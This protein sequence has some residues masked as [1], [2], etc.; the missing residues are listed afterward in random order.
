MASRVKPNSESTPN[1]ELGVQVYFLI[2]R[3]SSDYR[4]SYYE[5]SAQ[6][7]SQNIMES[8]ADKSTTIPMRTGIIEN[9]LV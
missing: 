4:S 8:T 2:I 1:N 7:G 9:K 3:G 5:I 6:L